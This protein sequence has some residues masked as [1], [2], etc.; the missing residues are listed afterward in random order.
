[1]SRAARPAAQSVLRIASA[2]AEL[3]KGLDAIRADH[4]ARFRA[5]GAK[6]VTFRRDPAAGSDGYTIAAD[7]RGISIRYGRVSSAFR[8]LG[9]LMAE[10]AAALAGLAITES[11]P[12]S[13]RG[14]MIDCSRNAVMRPDALQGFMRRV[15]LMGVNMIM[16][17]TEDTYE[18]PGEPFFG[19]L[20]GPYTQRELKAID[21]YAVTLGIEMIPCIQTLGHMEQLLQWDPCFPLRDTHHILL[22]GEKKTYDF[23]RKT[24]RAASA[25]VRSR[26]IHVGMDE[27]HGLGTGQYL[28][29][30]GKRRT[31]DIMNEHLKQ[32]RNIC[33]DE[34]LK[35]M[36]WSDM[37]FRLG[38]KTHDYYDLKWKIPGDV[39]KDIPKDVQLVYWDYY[40]AD[41]EF[42]RKMIAFHRSLGS[43][44]LMGGGIWT[45]GIQWCALHW[46]FTAVSAC[47]TAC[48][49]EGLKEV[50]MTM[51]GDEGT[52][53]DYFSA[54]PGIQHFCELAFNPEA[55]RDTTRRGFRATC[56]CDMDPWVGAADINTIPTIEKPEMSY[57][58]TAKGLL[59][60]DPLLAI[61]DVHAKKCDLAPHYRKMADQAA[62]AA[63]AGGLADRLLYAAGIAE[64]LAWKVNLR[65]HLAAAYQSRDR[66]A[67]RRIRDTELRETARAVDALWKHHRALWLG[68]NKPFGWEVLEHRYGGLKARLETVR[69]RLDD[70]LDGTIDEIPELA[71][72]ILDPWAHVKGSVVS[73]NHARMKTPSCIK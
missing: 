15:A 59:W 52:E 8:A 2:P 40:H 56:G 17:Y 66:K 26:R 71:A 13:M 39:V 62:A 29:K 67:L 61:F 7:A 30:F 32:V 11:S 70:Y 23:I 1:M 34:G 9:R 19:Y 44:P 35:P 31:F 18:V 57:A 43:E 6:P 22:S 72:K 5:S 27:A 14:L 33:E 51:W 24:I 73:I 48:R 60:E 16:L 54:L 21:D 55:D 42:Y 50:F 46:A 63:R 10:P 45:W 47:M 36:I 20:R 3:R 69:Q 65:R 25:P 58:N 41:P 37:Y 4:P 53:C 38:S 49:Q 68:M 64:V 28:K 12:F